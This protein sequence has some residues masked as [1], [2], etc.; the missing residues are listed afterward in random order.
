M[1]FFSIHSSSSRRGN[2]HFPVTRDAGI[3]P[4]FTSA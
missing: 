4:A 2:S 3:L 1:A